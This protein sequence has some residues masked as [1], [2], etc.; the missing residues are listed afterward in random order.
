MTK[1]DTHR[2]ELVACARCPRLV[3]FRT[4]VT[5]TKKAF[6]GDVYWSRP[7]PG[8]G[9][10]KARVVLVGLAPAPHGSNRTGRMFT[11]DGTDGMG[12][13]DFLMRAL[14]AT[15]FA[16]RDSSVRADDGLALTD[17]WMT[18]AVRCAPPDNKPAPDE[19]ANC[20]PWLDRELAL[21]PRVRVVVALGK[22]AFDR[23]VLSFGARG[24]EIPRPRPKFAHGAEVRLGGA[25]PVL[26]ATY[27]PSRQNTQTGKLSPGM[28]ADVFRQAARIASDRGRVSGG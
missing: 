10:A 4:E 22:L 25:F 14:H 28:L 1:L 23:L 5:G 19:V 24:A 16:N 7:V 2:A 26:L 20:A 17:L 18:A 13:S 6:A 21:L 3:R 11:G 27:H 8:F 9:D 15:G 12:S